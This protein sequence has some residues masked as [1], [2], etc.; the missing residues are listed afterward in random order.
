MKRTVIFIILIC[1][2]LAFIPGCVKNSDTQEGYAYVTID[3]SYADKGIILSEY[4]VKLEKGSKVFDITFTACK[5]NELLISSRGIGAAR[6]VEGIADLYEFDYGPASGWVF[7][8]NSESASK[9]SGVYE[10]K[11]GD[12]IKW[13]YVIE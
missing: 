8:V 3:A 9:S 10:V 12:I 5:D 11:E 13:E 2:M 1:L 7:Y 6:Y 4:A